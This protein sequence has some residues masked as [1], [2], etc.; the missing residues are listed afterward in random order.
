MITAYPHFSFT[1]IHECLFH[2]HDRFTASQYLDLVCYR[3]RV[4]VLVF[5]ILCSTKKKETIRFVGILAL[6]L[7]ET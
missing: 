4:I 6:R 2:I 3:A 1:A 7:E 5:W